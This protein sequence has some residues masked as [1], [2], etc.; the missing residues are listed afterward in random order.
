MREAVPFG[1]AKSEEV[2]WGLSQEQRILELWASKSPTAK[3]LARGFLKAG[4]H[5]DFDF[6]V[7]DK[8][9]LVL[10][11]VEVKIRRTSFA[12]YG[13][14]IFPLRK[15][16]LAVEVMQRTRIPIVGVVEYGCGTLVQCALSRKPAKQRDIS[17]RDRPGMRP[18]PH[19]FFNGSQL[20]VLKKGKR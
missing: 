8:K 14:A 17:R 2:E 18:V 11:Y 6:V 3:K 5:D 1:S 10:C 20:T 4:A 15:H 7:F 19:V 9:G 13:D 12:E 16:Q